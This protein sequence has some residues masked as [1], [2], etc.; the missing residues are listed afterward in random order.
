MKVDGIA[1]CV[2]FHMFSFLNSS[3]KYFLTKNQ[4]EFLFLTKQGLGHDCGPCY[5][6]ASRSEYR[7]SVGG[8]FFC[9]DSCRSGYANRI[10]IFQR[11]HMSLYRLLGTIDFDPIRV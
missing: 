1:S 9:L 10:A 6:D 3:D 7:R 11:S 4:S 8:G 2:A 5:R